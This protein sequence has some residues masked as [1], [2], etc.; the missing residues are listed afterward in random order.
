MLEHGGPLS[1]RIA[2]FTALLKAQDQ[3]IRTYK[4]KYQ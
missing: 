4:Q 3:I 1:E 2:Q